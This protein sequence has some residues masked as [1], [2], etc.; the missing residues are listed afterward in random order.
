M[1]SSDTA[2]P[3]RSPPPAPAPPAPAPPAPASPAPPAPAPSWMPELSS[4]PSSLLSS[5]PRSRR[6]LR[7]LTLVML[8]LS[9]LS[10]WTVSASN[11]PV[12]EASQKVSAS[13]Q[14]T[15]SASSR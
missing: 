14:P 6:P 1:S 15:S 3:S 12:W 4:L 8:A 7:S 10:Q 5:L 9:W 11:Q 13:M 2:L